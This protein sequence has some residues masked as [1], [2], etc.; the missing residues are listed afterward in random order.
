MGRAVRGP[1]GQLR[2]PGNKG[3]VVVAQL[4]PQA[5][6]SGVSICKTHAYNLRC[7][8]SDTISRSMITMRSN[9]SRIR[10]RYSAPNLRFTVLT[11]GPQYRGELRMTSPRP[12]SSISS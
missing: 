8:I 2:D 12:D 4:P 7:S 10:T 11:D 6:A 1:L 3:S 9:T 5:F